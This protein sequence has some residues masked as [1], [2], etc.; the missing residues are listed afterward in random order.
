MPEGI[1]LAG[2]LFGALAGSPDFIDSD[3][4]AERRIGFLPDLW[5]C[6]VIRF[7]CTINDRIEGRVDFA[8]L[9]NILGFLVRLIADAVGIRPGCGNQKIERLHPSVAGA[10]GHDVKEF[11][12][13]LGMQLV[14]YHAV[15][16]KAVLR[17]RL[18]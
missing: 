7:I 11:P 9:Q 16:V 6:P 14:K 17:I 8:T 18:R 3:R 10:L 1:L 12:V 5:V 2:I 15:D 4:D 13:G